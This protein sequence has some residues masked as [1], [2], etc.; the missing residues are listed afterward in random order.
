MCFRCDVIT[1]LVLNSSNYYFLVG[2]TT[3]TTTTPTTTITTTRRITATAASTATTAIMAS[4]AATATTTNTAVTKN[5]APTNS[6]NHTTSIDT[7]TTHSVTGNDATFTKTVGGIVGGIVAISMMILL[8]LY[9]RLEWLYIV[10]KIWHLL[11][12]SILLLLESS[13]TSLA[14]RTFF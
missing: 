8:F 14:T 10:L 3:T 5:S 13:R 4:T 12:T 6:K 9:A 2:L 7:Q 11:N 1:I